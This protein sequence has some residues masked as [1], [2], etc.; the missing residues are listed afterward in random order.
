MT[1][2][3]QATQ[4]AHDLWDDAA[5]R[6]RRVPGH[7]RQLSADWRDYRLT[8]HRDEVRA[9]GKVLLL[10]SAGVAAWLAYRAVQRRRSGQT[11]TS[12]ADYDHV[13]E[14]S[15]ESFP[16]SDPPSFTPGAV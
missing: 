3:D 11:P 12:E 4:H 8:D 6:L 15:M 1:T 13:D 5:S 9:A 2:L 14:A 16:A 7:V 10:A